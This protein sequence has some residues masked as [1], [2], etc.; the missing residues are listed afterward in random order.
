MYKQRLKFKNDVVSEVGSETHFVRRCIGC[1]QR[2]LKKDLIRFVMVDEDLIWD[3]KHRMSGRSVYFHPKKSCWVKMADIKLWKHAFK[4][5][6]FVKREKVI[7]L[8]NQIK[9]LI[10]TVE[11]NRDV[12]TS[13]LGK[14]RL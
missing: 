7:D 11:E 13:L 4:N 1:R 10:P 2:A 9:G 14:V 8:M 6:E 5:S 3:E 12:K